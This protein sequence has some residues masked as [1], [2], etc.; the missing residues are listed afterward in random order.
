[1][2][3][4]TLILYLFLYLM[5]TVMLKQNFN[6]DQKYAYISAFCF[7]FMAYLNALQVYFL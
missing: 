4:R 6:P 5:C 7:Q 2:S 3:L 1:M